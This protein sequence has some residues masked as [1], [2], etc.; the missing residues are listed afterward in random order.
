MLTGD[1][2]VPSNATGG[3]VI[4]TVNGSQTNGVIFKIGGKPDAPE[5][6]RIAS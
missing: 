4:V 6:P 5:K 2:I 3:F 1:S